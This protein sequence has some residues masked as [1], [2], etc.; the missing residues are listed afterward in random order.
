M[1][2][3]VAADMQK[4]RWKDAGNKGFI[5][6]GVWKYSQHP[7]YFGEML[8]WASLCVSCTNGLPTAGQKALAIASPAFVCYL[9]RFVSG[10]P[11]LQKAAKAK[12]G[13]DPKYLQYVARTSLLVPWPPKSEP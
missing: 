4:S 13:G 11:L 9:L 3:E 1:I 6:R 10:V 12:Y 5:E 8:L 2:L 7:N